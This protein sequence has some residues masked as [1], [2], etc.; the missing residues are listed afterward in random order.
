MHSKPKRFIVEI[1]TGIDIHGEDVTRAACRAVKD[2]VSRS[3][4]CGLVEILEVPSLDE[5]Q[6]D[7]L[8]AAPD[9]ERVDLERVKA[10]VPIGRKAARAVA[11]GMK[12]QG[13]CVPQFAPQC[14]QIVVV[15]VAVTVSVNP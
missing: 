14:D 10:E 9:P 2:A 3:C 6:V 15:N 12:A 1:G 11:G 5:V 8:V 13:L 4:L 7:I